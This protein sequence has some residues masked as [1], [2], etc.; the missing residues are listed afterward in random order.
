MPLPAM[1]D[2]AMKVAQQHIKN[3]EE[4]IRAIKK[5]NLYDKTFIL[6]LRII[7][8]LLNGGTLLLNIL[9]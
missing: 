3:Q 1:S 6:Y 4:A 5:N 9:V 8:S 2:L 7:Y